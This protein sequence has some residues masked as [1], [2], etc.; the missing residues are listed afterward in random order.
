MEVACSRPWAFSTGWVPT[1]GSMGGQV[2]GQPLDEGQSSS[3]PSFRARRR[4]ARAS[5]P[6]MRTQGR[7]PAATRSAARL[8]S[9]WGM[10]PPIPDNRVSAFSIPRR[11]ARRGAGSPWRS[12]REWTI[13]QWVM[14]PTDAFPASARASSVEAA[15]SSKGSGAA[16]GS[17]SRF[18]T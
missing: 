7:S 3:T 13:Q 12:D 8:T 10:F 14:S 6:A 18:V 4:V 1:S 5:A 9:H 17:S 11:A 15:I 16:T 2:S